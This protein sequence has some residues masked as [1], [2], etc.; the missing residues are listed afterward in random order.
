MPYQTNVP[1]DLALCFIAWAYTAHLLNV[2]ERRR[3]DGRR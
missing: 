2:Y 3:H 1:L